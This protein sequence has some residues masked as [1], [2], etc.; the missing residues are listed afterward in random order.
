MS[1][2]DKR[3]LNLIKAIRKEAKVKEPKTLV[4]PKR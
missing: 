4:K 2:I 3:T 1:F